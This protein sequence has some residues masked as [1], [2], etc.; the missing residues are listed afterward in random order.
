MQFA[1]LAALAVFIVGL[2]GWGWGVRRAFGMGAAADSAS[3]TLGLG[4]AGLIFL[5][6]V[7]NLIRLAG[8]PA[9][10]G[11]VLG[12]LVL[13]W[14]GRGEVRAWAARLSWRDFAIAVP[15]LL[16]LAFTVATQLPPAAYNAADDYAKY[17]FH[18]VRMLA[19]GT[20]FGSPLSDLG[21]ETLGGKAFL[22]GFVAALFALTALNVTDAVLGLLLCLLL[23]AHFSRGVGALVV[24]SGLGVLSVIA[25]DPQYMNISALYLGAALMMVAIALT[26]EEENAAALGLVYAALIALKTTFALFV[27]MHLLLV[28]IALMVAGRRRWF[29]VRVAGW[30]VVFV[31]PWVLLHAPHYFS[32]LTAPVNAVQNFGAGPR[33]AFG[34]FST[35]WLTYGS[36]F[37]QFTLTVLAGVAAALV[38]LW[39]AVRADVKLPLLMGAA[40]GLTGAIAYLVM[41]YVFGPRLSGTGE[42]TRYFVPFAIGTV[43][44]VLGIAAK[45][46]A[47]G[48]WRNWAAVGL[49]GLPVVIFA[50]SMPARAVEAVQARFILA[51]PFARTED[52]RNLNALVLSHAMAERVRSLQHMVPAGETLTVWINAPFA[53]DL[54][55][56]PVVDMDSAGLATPWAALPASGYII[57]EYGGYAMPMAPDGVAR[58]G[59]A[60]V[61]ERMIA[62]AE[63]RFSALLERYAE[64]GTLVFKDERFAVIRMPGS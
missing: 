53:L 1:I 57:W 38:L 34:L 54:K 10:L 64:E 4:L 23:A 21:S 61:H 50:P 51:F 46:L 35:F 56:N 25:I 8:A 48:G 24:V 42:A 19:T 12:G 60:G 9:L 29:G 18:P 32:A 6:G 11:L 40:A 15:V 5:G 52:Y 13:A 26:V 2:W 7:L 31:S 45:H 17:F 55:R 63:L 16:I 30:T 28:G 62:G 33:E 14:V 58:S 41:F 20:L 37:L 22:D 3:L 59:I 39:R 43:P 27:V 47:R 44:A 36:S 49:A